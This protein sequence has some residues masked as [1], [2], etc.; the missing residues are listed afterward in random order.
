MLEPD[1]IDQISQLV[2]EHGLDE[3]LGLSLLKKTMG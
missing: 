2:I 3:A 1:V